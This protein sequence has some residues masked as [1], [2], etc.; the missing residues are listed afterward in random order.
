MI[1]LKKRSL[2]NKR[3]VT[4]LRCVGALVLQGQFT[5]ALQSCSI[6]RI[7]FSQTR[8]HDA[9]ERVYVLDVGGHTIKAGTA[10]EAD[11]SQ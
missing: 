1:K 2:F 8:K 6:F 5:L 4:S 10:G 11:P 9:M 7:T 3:C